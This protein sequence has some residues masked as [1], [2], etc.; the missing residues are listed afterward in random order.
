MDKVRLAY[1]VL[2]G[3]DFYKLGSLAKRPMC[4]IE[5]NASFFKHTDGLYYPSFPLTIEGLERGEDESG[6]PGYVFTTGVRTGSV[7]KF[8][9]T[10]EIVVGETL[11]LDCQDRFWA[12]KSDEL[13]GKNSRHSVE[14]INGARMLGYRFAMTSWRKKMRQEGQINIIDCQRRLFGL[15]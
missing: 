8:K 14:R 3:N 1:Y 12:V 7:F 13:A 2:N 4:W 10:V 5:L 15:P 6:M 11:L 9:T